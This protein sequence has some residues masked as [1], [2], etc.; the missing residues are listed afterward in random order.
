MSHLTEQ[1]FDVAKGVNENT[2]S[3][4]A[5]QLMRYFMQSRKLTASKATVKAKF[6]QMSKPKAFSEFIWNAIDAGSTTIE[7]TTDIDKEAD[8]INSIIIEDNGSGFELS[9]GKSPFDYFEQ[10]KK[11][12]SNDYLMRG[13][14]GRGRLSFF[15]FCDSASWRTVSKDKKPIE[16]NITE[17]SL[18]KF[19][20]LEV[21]NNNRPLSNGTTVTFNSFSVSA[22]NFVSNVT[23]Y[24]EEN[25][26]W[27]NFFK[28]DLRI[29]L[30]GKRLST[31]PPRVSTSY[32]ETIDNDPVQYDLHV[33][34]KKI[35]EEECTIFYCDE[36]NNVV[37]KT[38][39]KPKNSYFYT[40]IVKSPW[41]NQFCTENDGLATKFDKTASKFLSISRIANEKIKSVYDNL[42]K[43]AID[44]LI[45]EYTKCGIIPKSQNNALANFKTQ[46]LKDAIRVIYNADS[47]VF[48]SLNTNKQ[49]KILVKLI[50]KIVNS[51]DPKAL[52]DALDGI[53]SL[54][55]TE[56]R[57]L[58]NSLEK[59]AMGNMVR[60][61]NK[62][63]N[64]LYALD[65]FEQLLANKK[66]SYEVA[67]IQRVIESNLW[68]FGEEYN[69]VTTEE[70]KF[71][72][73]LRK[74][75][76]F[77][78]EDLNALDDFE[79]EVF[80]PKHFDKY[81]V[82]HEN[83][84]KEMDV[85]AT[86]KLPMY[87]QGEQYYRHLVLELK[88]PSV[89]LTDKEYDQI[90]GYVKVIKSEEKFNTKNDQ[91]DFVL[92]GNRITE[93][94][95]RRAMIDMQLNNQREKGK[96]G[97]LIDDGN[98]RVWIKEWTDVIGDYKLRYNHIIHTLNIKYAESKEEKSPDTLTQDI[99]NLTTA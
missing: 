73:A 79:N 2:R 56:L 57:M 97:L 5:N 41:F 27:I 84:N 80:P 18:D 89:K 67:H 60:T 51:E 15:K 35:D 91:W 54:D 55:E 96:K 17:G 19:N 61:I 29:N 90:T 63:E 88:R 70:E 39:S 82:Q 9:D 50:D 4:L 6:K 1:K 32:E 36:M 95:H 76:K 86:Q 44:E 48:D 69:V 77:K 87:E 40:C 68:I 74:L 93:S 24:L 37:Y 30:N 11:K 43:S 94:S 58:S 47:S 75:L 8:H 38:K 53:V 22:D 25:V 31:K 45:D 28:A 62:L 65:L 12:G 13:R 7:I 14:H 33:W 49:K 46:Q 81:K 72:K 59:V 3:Y 92:V 34:N 78:N 85:F 66:D 42:R 23:E 26:T 52:F 10:S 83:K 21:K 98:I 64:R 16:L 71:D 99:K 20:I